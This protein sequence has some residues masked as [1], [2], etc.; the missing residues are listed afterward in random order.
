MSKKHTLSIFAFLNE[1]TLDY[2]FDNQAFM[3]FVPPQY[4]VLS[5]V[6]LLNICNLKIKQNTRFQPQKL[7]ILSSIG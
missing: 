6:Y 5:L 7:I 1:K 3:G 2:L 4:L